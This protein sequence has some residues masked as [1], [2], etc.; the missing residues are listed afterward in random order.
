MTKKDLLIIFILT[1]FLSIIVFFIK[2]YFF[3]WMENAI[4]EEYIDRSIYTDLDSWKKIN[5]VDNK[6]KDNIKKNENETIIYNTWAEVKEIK[7]EK[8]LNIKFYYIPSDFKSETIIQTIIIRNVLSSNPFL[9]LSDSLWIDFFKERIDVRWKMK[10]WKVK[11]YWVLNLAN[12]ELVSVFIHEL[13]HYIDIYFLNN[14]NEDDYDYSKDFYDLA[15]DSTKTIKANMKWNDF[16]SW[17]S[18]TNKY[19]DFAETF[20]YYVLHNEDFQ[21]KAKDSAILRQK[22][23]FFGKHIF[24]NNEFIQV[25]FWDQEELKDYYRDITKIDIKLEKFLQYLKNPI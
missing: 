9:V 18:M 7:K 6:E 13:A 2:I 3:S 8:S 15:W 12:K 5:I 23:D 24:K 1:L 10:N 16:V 22:Y 17:Y 4:E 11:L 19:E 25:D 20:T 21:L 14:D